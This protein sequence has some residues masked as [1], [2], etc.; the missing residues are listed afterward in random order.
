MTGQFMPSYTNGSTSQRERQPVN[1]LDDP[2]IVTVIKP[3]PP[4]G[5]VQTVVYEQIAKVSLSHISSLFSTQG[6]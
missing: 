5:K 2:S 4:P 6:T 3:I 1:E